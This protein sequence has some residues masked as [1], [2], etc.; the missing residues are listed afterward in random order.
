MWR[1]ILRACGFIALG[2]VGTALILCLAVLFTDY[3]RASL[4]TGPRVYVDAW[5]HGYVH[6]EGTWI[7]ESQAQA[8]P[9]QVTSLTC[10]RNQQC[11]SSTAQIASGMLS[12]DASDYRIEA[13]T[14]DTLVFTDKSPI[15]VDYVYSISRATQTLA[16]V[17]TKKPDARADTC[18]W[19]DKAPLKL[20][21]T[22]G[23]DVWKRLADT[24]W[25]E[26]QPFFWAAL[27]LWWTAV[28]FFGSRRKSGRA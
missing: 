27:A 18:S 1:W 12:V 11:T 3:P 5:D 20:S 15:C 13:W 22:N 2:I 6:A 19:M 16:G 8:F 4:P 23:F 9:L 17:R 14:I 26:T 7:I 21:L 28:L 25:S 10:V 24:A